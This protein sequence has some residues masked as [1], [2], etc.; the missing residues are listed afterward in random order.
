MYAF[1]GKCSVTF[2]RNFSFTKGST[3]SWRGVA[4]LGQIVWVPAEL[5]CYLGMS[6]TRKVIWSIRGKF[7]GRSCPTV[8]YLF[9]EPVP[10]VRS[11][12]KRTVVWFLVSAAFCIWS[13]FK[14]RAS[15]STVLGNW[16]MMCCESPVVDVLY[17]VGFSS[18]LVEGHRVWD[19]RW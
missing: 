13:A 5:L 1:Y 4:C 15:P 2:K 3:S 11:A 7:V 17:A 12:K 9:W 19:K 10:L 8:A 14:L 18:R 6:V 16:I